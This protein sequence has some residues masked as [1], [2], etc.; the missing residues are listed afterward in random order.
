MKKV[1]EQIN[2]F[3]SKDTEFEGKLS[4]SGEVRIDGRYSGEIM[5]EGILVIGESAYLEADVR[6]S[7]LVISGEVHGNITADKKIE[8]NSQGKVLGN[9]SAPIITIEEGGIFEG[10]CKMQG[11]AGSEEAND[12]IKVLRSDSSKAGVDDKV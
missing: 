10:A 3:L 7:R 5:A 12:K 4:F 6:A 11:K 1:K 2:G 9:I 8:I